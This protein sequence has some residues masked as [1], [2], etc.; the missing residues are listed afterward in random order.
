M[1][2]ERRSRGPGGPRRAAALVDRGSREHYEDALLYDHEYRRRRRDVAFYREEAHRLLGGPGTVLELACGSGRVT[3]A[4]VR[5]GH[6]VIGL[7][8]SRPM[9]A[10]AAARAGR[11]GRAARE[12]VHLVRADMR[13]FALARRFPLVVM[14]FN[15]FEHLY[16]RV[17]VAACL[18]RVRE[19]LEP[20]GRFVFDVQNPNLRWL[21][22]D[23]D[24]RW[25]RTLFRHPVTGRRMAYSTNHVYDPVSQIA[26]IRLYYDPV[27]GGGRPRVVHLSQRKFF[28]AEL[29]ALLAHGG[30]A[31]EA[32][33]GDFSRG[34]LDGDAESQV[35]VCRLR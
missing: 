17:D 13:R 28:P 22:R 30:F 12:R 21:T 8:L 32:R 16:T 7:D 1:P 14:A 35:L 6:R 34:P 19:H 26:L 27:E 10:R 5:E 18:A 11:L 29:E 33:Y 31:V 23:P 2:G 9:L 25:A 24:R 20:G 3:T 15:S 4:L